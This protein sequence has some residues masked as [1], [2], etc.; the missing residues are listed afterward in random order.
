MRRK[1]RAA[2][3]KHLRGWGG[4]GTHHPEPFSKRRAGQ[5]RRE[6]RR[7]KVTVVRATAQVEQENFSCSTCSG[8]AIEDEK[9]CFLCKLYWEDVKAG[10]FS[11]PLNFGREDWD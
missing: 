8:I 5:E 2:R 4:A 3:A 1:Q 9:H 7:F 10:M 6:E 11:S